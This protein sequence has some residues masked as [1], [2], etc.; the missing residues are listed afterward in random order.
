MTTT[1]TLKSALILLAT[2]TGACTM[3][4]DDPPPVFNVSDD[5]LYEAA[6]EAADQWC[7]ETGHCATVNH[8]SEDVNVSWNDAN[9]MVT[10]RGGL[11]CA[12]AAQV[13]M[14]S[15]HI[16][17]AKDLIYTDDCRHYVAA[18]DGT[19]QG[20]DGRMYARADDNTDLVAVLAHEMGHLWHYEHSA[21]ELSIMAS[22]NLW[23][24]TVDASHLDSYYADK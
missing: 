8:T 18:E 2:L 6:K 7:K 24:T 4:V 12:T 3:I 22:P 10:K 16:Y 13:V 19:K 5:T 11:H 21:D 17:V 1:T 14:G 20:P 9:D 23:A 15:D